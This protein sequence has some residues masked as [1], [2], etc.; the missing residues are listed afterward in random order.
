MILKHFVLQKQNLVAIPGVHFL[1][2][3][4]TIFEMIQ[5]P[6]MTVKVYRGAERLLGETSHREGV[7]PTTSL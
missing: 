1:E 2:E 6:V 7:K 3:L 5:Q 4:S